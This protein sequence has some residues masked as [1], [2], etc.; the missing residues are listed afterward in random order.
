MTVR[1]ERPCRPTVAHSPA[2][3]QGQDD[4]AEAAAGTSGATSKSSQL[5]GRPQSW[6]V[7]VADTTSTVLGD[8]KACVRFLA[9]VLP[10]LAAV[11]CVVVLSSWF[12]G[13]G[14][15]AVS[16]GSG[17]HAVAHLGR[18]GRLRRQRFPLLDCDQRPDLRTSG[19]VG[20]FADDTAGPSIVTGRRP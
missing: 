12:V 19:S 13:M 3:G 1:A 5:I 8:T 4:S 11:V 15:G 18:R 9:V 6:L 2:C 14:L 7:Y 16:A 20:Q 10:I 17:I